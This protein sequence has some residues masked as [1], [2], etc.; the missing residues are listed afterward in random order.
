MNSNMLRGA[1]LMG[2][3]ALV[4]AKSGSSA[5]QHPLGP[6]VDMFGSTIGEYQGQDTEYWDIDAP[7]DGDLSSD[8][9]GEGW[10]SGGGDADDDSGIRPFIL[11]EPR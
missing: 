8:E 3:L 9:T 11:L 2:L 6:T 1:M 5:P 4:S 10:E 7:S